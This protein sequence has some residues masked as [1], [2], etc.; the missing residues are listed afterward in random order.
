MERAQIDS[1]RDKWILVNG[2]TGGMG[3]A[4]VQMAKHFGLNVIATGGTD[5][6]LKV[7]KEVG[8][9]D[10]VINYNKNPNFSKDVKKLTNGAGADIVFDPVGGDAFD[11]ALRST[12]F[13]ARVCIVGFTSGKHP[14]IPANYALIK[15]LAILGCRAGEYILH[16][17]TMDPDT[18]LKKM[19]K[20]AQSPALAPHV[21]SVYPFTS[22]G[23][24]AAFKELQDRKVI[25]RVCVDVSQEDKKLSSRL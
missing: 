4:A 3:F 17:P 12:A 6:K 10:E 21:S 25:G 13:G 9:A 14:N 1:S 16:K 20:L 5:E 19:I 22:A 2:A 15:C 23:V 18:R 24:Q 11:Q 7:V 8:G